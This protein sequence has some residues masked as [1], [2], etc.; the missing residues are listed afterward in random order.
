M[1][2]EKGENKNERWKLNTLRDVK[3][4]ID[5][6]GVHKDRGPMNIVKL[7]LIIIKFNTEL[8][9]PILLNIY[10]NVLLTGIAPPS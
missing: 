2:R 5:K 10:N 1:H 8:L 7:L 6:I 4:A 9:A 3:S